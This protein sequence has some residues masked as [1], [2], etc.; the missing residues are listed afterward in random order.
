[1]LQLHERP[2]MV[3]DATLFGYMRLG[4]EAAAE[5]V[6]EIARQCRRYDGT[7]TLLWHNSSLPTAR[8][9]HWYEALIATIANAL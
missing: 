5:A 1:M 2:L 8:D 7:L 3:M 4:S 9:Q 6:L